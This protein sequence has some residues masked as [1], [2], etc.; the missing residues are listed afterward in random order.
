MRILH[1]T[2]CLR[3]GGI[4]NFLLSLLPE[5]V[6]QKN[7]VTLIVIEQYDYD[8]CRHLD[9]VL[10]SNGVKVICLNKAKHNKV[11]M[12]RTIIACRSVIG[13]IRP[14]IVNTHGTMSHIYGAVSVIGKP[15][16]QVITVHNAPEPW[17][18]SCK[19]LC[20]GKPLIFCSKSAFDIRQQNASLMAAIDNGISPEI[21]RSTDKVDLRQDLSLKPSDQVIVLVGSLRPQKNYEFLKD[22]VD[23]V[24]DPSLHF[25]ICGGNY[26]E[27]YIQASVFDGYEKNIHLLGLRSDVS[28]IENGA[29]L[30]MSC[31]KFEGLPIAV[32]EAYFNGIPCVLSPIPQHKNIA[33]VYK[34]Y[35]P[36]SFDAVSF[37]KMIKEA[38]S[39]KEPHNE[40]YKKR[41]EQI[42]QYCISTTCKKYLDFYSKIL[43]D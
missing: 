15:F 14:N 31:A 25:C 21:V 18:L 38:L 17:P 20:N 27:G 3:G 29:D 13:K 24:H 22:I 1:I 28:A 41:E 10:T 34:V 7:E 33:N 9:S 30:F 2:D 42:A 39:E 26:G 11:S 12:L 5:Q 36:N 43:N 4:Q 35:I 23:E 8:Y 19:L 32:L 16:P 37:S 40:I 6:K